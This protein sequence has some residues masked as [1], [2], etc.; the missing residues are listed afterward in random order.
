VPW[1][2]FGVE[3]LWELSGVGLGGMVWG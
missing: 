3:W 1:P 2:D